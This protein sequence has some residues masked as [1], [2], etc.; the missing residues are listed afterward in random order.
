MGEE[1]KK[2]RQ[3]SYHKY[4]EKQKQKTETKKKKRRK[5]HKPLNSGVKLKR[6]LNF[7]ND[8]EIIKH[9]ICKKISFVR[10]TLKQNSNYNS[11]GL[12]KKQL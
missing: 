12:I 9:I 10:Q 4:Y 5:K 3:I 11:V 8:I 1:E 7:L 6:N 2:E